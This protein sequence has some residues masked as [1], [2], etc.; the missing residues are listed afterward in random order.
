M[1]TNAGFNRFAPRAAGAV[2]PNRWDVLL[3]PLVIGTLFLITWGSGKM[4][5]PYVLGTPIP[6][7]LEPGNLPEYALRTTL[8]MTLAML[9]S[10]AFAL[11]YGSLAA[12]SVAAGRVLIPLLD[13][14]QSIPILGFLS[15][16]V[17]GFVRLFPGSM[18]GPELAAVFAIFTSQAWNLTFSYYASLRMVPR[19][20]YEVS[21]ML[22]LSPWQ[23]FFRLEAPYA[24]PGLIWNMMMSVAGGWFFVVASE[25]ITV[26]NMSIQLPG[27]GSYI[28]L[29]IRSE[30]LPAVGYA[31]LAMF[32][33][34]L[35]TDQL[36]FRPLVAW[37]ERFKFEFT[38]NQ[39][40]PR[41]WFL[42]LLRRAQFTRMFLAAVMRGMVVV[43]LVSALLASRQARQA[44]AWP[45]RLRWSVDGA[46]LDRYWNALVVMAAAASTFALIRFVHAAVS[47]QEV[48]Q[49]LLLGLITGARVLLLVALASLLWVPI[50]IW[51][52]LNPRIGQPAQPIVV[53]LAAFP[54]NL[55]FP[56]AISAIVGFH[57]D[58]EIWLSPL[59]ILGTQWYIL[60]NVV[61][62]AAALPSDLQEAAANIGLRGGMRW[63][64][65]LLPSVFPSYVTGA[66]TASGGAWNASVVSELVN[67]GSTSLSATGLGA[68][69]ATQTA[70]GDYPRVAL[71]VVVMS[72]YVVL[73]N[74]VVW[75]RLY[76]MAEQRFSFV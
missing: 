56:V 13:I 73:F 74:R 32:I 66:V 55:F 49:V 10:L 16:S 47:F 34:I 37:G 9:G 36:L 57:L 72:L 38:E 61:S 58:P 26:D 54:A 31:I 21:R 33:V 2:G 46:L 50:G 39:R 5:A 18:L 43:Q 8:R 62:A 19:D 65:L 29:A 3:L 7:S 71:G 69:I 22:K 44:F 17:V 15:I 35:A 59:M 42:S 12:K 45:R 67:W 27:I 64:R 52:G 40:P 41:S 24:M 70:A 53:L 23:Q 25:A 11:L 4:N 51:I 60:F 63:T 30:D 68:Y 14:L 6:I 48:G 75:K 76:M 1:T 28:A 20:L